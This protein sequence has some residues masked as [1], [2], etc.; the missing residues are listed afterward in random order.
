MNDISVVLKDLIK[1]ELQ[2]VKEVSAND[3]TDMSPG[4][5]DSQKTVVNRNK[6]SRTTEMK[7]LRTGFNYYHAVVV[8]KF[9]EA[10]KL[11]GATG[12]L[13]NRLA[14]KATQQLDQTTAVDPQ[15]ILNIV[16]SS[17]TTALRDLV[18]GTRQKA[19]ELFPIAIDENTQESKE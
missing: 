8:S 3:K 10:Q 1:E 17:Y 5:H 19:K 14:Q 2:R 7:D 11:T 13:I 6:L 16:Q 4:T 12:E 9:V 18:N 15:E